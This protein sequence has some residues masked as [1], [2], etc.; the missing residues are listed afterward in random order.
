MVVSEAAGDRTWVSGR[1]LTLIGDIDE[2][3]LVVVGRQ[4]RRSL[5]SLAECRVM[6]A[7]P[8]LATRAHAVSLLS[9]WATLF[10]HYCLGL[11]KFEV[12]TFAPCGPRLEL[13]AICMGGPRTGSLAYP[14]DKAHNGE[15]NF[16]LKSY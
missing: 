11:K 15:S 4:A 10:V 13:L 5:T 2:L 9:A 6:P 8:A 3:Q 12:E 7:T 14:W 1:A 16:Y